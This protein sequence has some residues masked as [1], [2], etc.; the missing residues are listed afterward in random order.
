L[1]SVVGRKA[2]NRVRADDLA[3]G[4]SAEVC[5]ANVEAEAEEG[6]VI[7]SVIENEIS[8]TFRAGFEGFE[9]VPGEVCFVADLD[10]GGTTIH[11]CREDV[12]Q[13]MAVEVGGIQNWIK[14]H[15]SWTGA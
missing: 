5:L 13:R 11:C 1:T 3:G 12:L 4:G 15:Y 6:S 7:R 10:P 14:S 2:K 9:E 8:F